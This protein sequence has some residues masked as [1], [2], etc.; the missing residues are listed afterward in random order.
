MWEIL[1]FRGSGGVAL[2]D[3]DFG[4][5]DTTEE[6]VI[7][8][9]VLK[10]TKSG[11]GRT[12]SDAD[13]YDEDMDE[14]EDDDEGDDDLLRSVTGHGNSIVEEG[15]ID[16]EEEEMERRWAFT[17]ESVDDYLRRRKLEDEQL[18]M[19]GAGRG[20][21]VGGI[22]GVPDGV[23]GAA[24]VPDGVERLE[25]GVGS[26]VESKGDT[27]LGRPVSGDWNSLRTEPSQESGSLYHSSGTVTGSASHVIESTTAGDDTETTKGKRKNLRVGFVDTVTLPEDS[28]QVE[29]DGEDVLTGDGV[30]V[31]V[32]P[33]IVEVGNTVK[34]RLSFKAVA[35]VVKFLSGSFGSFSKPLSALAIPE[36]PDDPTPSDSATVATGDT[37]PAVEMSPPASLHK[38]DLVLSVAAHDTQG[39][40]SQ[41]IIDLM[42]IQKGKQLQQQKQQ[43]QQQLDLQNEQQQPQPMTISPLPVTTA[44]EGAK[45]DNCSNRPAENATK[46]SVMSDDIPDEDLE[47][48]SPLPPPSRPTSRGGARGVLRRGLAVPDMPDIPLGDYVNS[49][50]STSLSDSV[51]SGIE[52][53]AVSSVMSS[54]EFEVPGVP[55]PHARSLLPLKSYDSTQGVDKT[56]VVL[57]DTHMPGGDETLG[58]G[59]STD[60]NEECVSTTN[61]VSP[62]APSH[63]RVKHDDTT[64]TNDVNVSTLSAASSTGPNTASHQVG[65]PTNSP[66]KLRI[67]IRF[68]DKLAT[69]SIPTASRSF[70]SPPPTQGTSV[71]PNVGITFGTRSGSAGG[72]LVEDIDHLPL[73]IHAPS[74]ADNKPASP[75][76]GFA[77]KGHHSVMSSQSLNTTTSATVYRPERLAPAPVPPQSALLMHDSHNDQGATAAGRVSSYHVGAAILPFDG[78]KRGKK[79][80][81]AL[82]GAYI[83]PLMKKKPSVFRAEDGKCTQKASAPPTSEE[84]DAGDIIEAG[85]EEV[86]VEEKE[87]QDLFIENCFKLSAALNHVAAPEPEWYNG[88]DSLHTD[89]EIYRMQLL[90]TTPVYTRLLHS[91]EITVS[92]RLRRLSALSSAT[93]DSSVGNSGVRLSLSDGCDVGEEIMGPECSGDGYNSTQGRLTSH[94][95]PRENGVDLSKRIDP[96]TFQDRCRN[97]GAG[98]PPLGAP[99]KAVTMSLDLATSL[100][101]SGYGISRSLAECENR[102][103]ASDTREG[104]SVVTTADEA[105]EAVRYRLKPHE[106]QLMNGE[107]IT[108]MTKV[109]ISYP[110]HCKG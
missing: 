42:A 11:F 61:T 85:R 64:T 13:A 38:S 22:S 26:V 6:T 52:H 4:L 18:A 43:Q 5:L 67:D 98:R 99:L 68:V 20:S 78:N 63:T 15:E 45:G 37:D 66:T 46:F 110:V 107:R 83:P 16:E 71:S 31:T 95:H 48:K 10:D 102:S 51:F 9:V 84:G 1:Y 70:V 96:K 17:S 94:S 29:P 21:G 3:I 35:G 60:G 25:H 36:G 93:G 81:G 12:L 88:H 39:R 40:V 23:E 24:G 97:A 101:R 59:N 80:K 108:T 49:L 72:L 69:M 105:K 32:V 55:P 90:G 56:L 30:D 33:P 87:Y 91:E 47:V 103:A 76:P 57:D 44:A 73:D 82:K 65:L 74:P 53:T 89:D 54:E 28:P 27:S 106:L 86:D 75:G 7:D 41:H 50:D 62:F 2:P 14:Q 92:E 77:E 109:F 8:K 19:A 58:L 34:E 100:E 104:L 79:V